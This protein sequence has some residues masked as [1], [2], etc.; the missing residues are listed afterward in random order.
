MGA[1]RGR[2]SGPVGGYDNCGR[3]RRRLQR[4]RR[5]KVRGRDCADERG[6]SG[7]QSGGGAGRGGDGAGCCRGRAG[8]RRRGNG[9]RDACVEGLLQRCCRIGFRG[10]ERS[11]RDHPSVEPD[12]PIR[13]QHCPHRRVTDQPHGRLRAVVDC[14][15]RP[16][17]RAV[18]PEG[19][20]DRA[21]RG[22]VLHR[23][24]GAAGLHVQRRK[25][26]SSAGGLQRRRHL[27]G[28]DPA[29]CLH[30]HAD[31]HLGEVLQDGHGPGWCQVPD[32]LVE[33]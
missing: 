1:V 31:L 32:V 24:L 8:H 4:R 22:A 13:C 12:S 3:C 27:L 10:G 33:R 2:T 11:E 28:F 30:V 21:G 6:D 9:H 5:R 25:P 18:L 16:G 14:A 23:V 7:R 15:R 29:G 26:V 20:A 17:G 19:Q